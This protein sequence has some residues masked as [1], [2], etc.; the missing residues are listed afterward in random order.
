MSD[1]I[2][3]SWQSDLPNN[4]NRGFIQAALEAAAKTIRNDQS[5]NIEPV[6]DRDTADVPGSPDIPS[7]IL[8]K[9]D[10]CQV[11]VCDVSK[12]NFGAASNFRP[13][14][15]PNVL[16]ELGYAIG[17]VGQER[18]IM[19]M[20]TAFGTLEQLPFDLRHKRVLTYSATSEDLD[21]AP[22]RKR[23]QSLLE[24]SLRTIF[25][26]PHRTPYN[27]EGHDHRL[28][29]LFL[30]KLPSQG[31]IRFINVVNMAGGSFRGTDLDHLW[32]FRHE[33][34]DAD[35]EFLDKDLEFLRKALF[36]LVKNY[37]H[38]IARNTFPTNITNLFTVPPEWEEEQPL[39]FKEVVDELHSMAE[40]IVFT[41]QALVR[42]GVAKLGISSIS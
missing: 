3:Y 37:T 16:L 8:G 25:G 18:I 29:R 30:L 26:N 24:S 19:V 35:H 2:F 27:R 33:W 11:F 40:Q 14:P 28:F 6:V 1:T 21:R 22:E 42:L 23:L 32:E 39:R 20:N 38:Q 4:T 12:I 34:T 10:I 5:L 41:H 36:T 13:T 7:T 9:I 17:T 15:N 31:S